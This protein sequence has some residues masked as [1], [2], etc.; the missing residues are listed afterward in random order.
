MSFDISNVCGLVKLAL[1]NNKIKKIEQNQFKCFKEL[2]YLNLTGNEIED[3]DENAFEALINLKELLLSSNKINYINHNWFK[4]LKKLERLY[5]FNNFLSEIESKKFLSLDKLEYLYLFGNRIKS[6]DENAF[7]GLKNLKI[8]LL[9]NNLIEK[10]EWTSCS[11]LSESLEV[12]NLNS[13]NIRVLTSL[14]C[15]KLT[16]LNLFN[17]KIQMI[18]TNFF[19]RLKSLEIVDL[20]KNLIENFDFLNK[21]DNKTRVFLKNNQEFKNHVAIRN[22]INM[23]YKNDFEGTR[24]N[25]FNIHCLEKYYLAHTGYENTTETSLK[26]EVSE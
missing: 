10:T 7:Y 19:Q 13:N 4:N 3:I 17:N 23:F 21:M 20:E 2:E 22:S 6:I 8:L 9:N 11:F 24:I 5:I 26:Y 14:N 25:Q 18:P 12:L 16:Q 1:F 15:R